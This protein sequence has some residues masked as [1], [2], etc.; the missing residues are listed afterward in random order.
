[1]K[2]SPVA[3]HPDSGHL[4]VAPCCSLLFSAGM[5]IA[6]LLCPDALRGSAPQEAP[7]QL[8]QVLTAR[9]AHL[10][11]EGHEATI[12]GDEL[13]GAGG[14]PLYEEVAA[15][16]PPINKLPTYGFVGTPDNRDKIG[17]EYGGRTANFDPAPYHPNIGSI[18]EQGKVLEGLVGGYLPVMRFVYPD[19]DRNW[20]ELLAFAPFRKVNS[21]GSIQP[22]WYRIARVEGGA[23]KWVKY[24]D[25]YH[26]FPPRIQ[27]EPALFWK[28]LIHLHA[29]WQ[30][31]F[32]GSMQVSLPD[33]RLANM[34]RMW[35]VREIMT[36][37]GDFP[38]YGVVD[39]N[40]AGSE[41]DGFPDTFTAG[42]EAMLL[43]G[44]VQRA[45]RYIDNY[46]RQFIDRKPLS[47]MTVTRFNES[48]RSY[49]EEGGAAERGLPT[50]NHIAGLLHLSP[51]YL[52][53]LLKQETG[54][55]ALELIHLYVISEAKNLLV[56]GDRTIAEIA[57]VLGFENPPYFSR[58]FK[59]EVGV[60]PKEFKGQIRN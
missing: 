30:K 43:W 60:S 39:R 57:Y 55:T 46:R 14:D 47:G 17:F 1:M 29:E 32:A 2:C 4:S 42:T 19:S 33:E 37:T 5:L 10:A 23:L 28:D 8:L 52:S 27:D 34:A 44:L 35:L 12:R 45:G 26:P 59:R 31:R 51:R 56:A 13:L 11:A 9:E 40:Y 20:C 6:L 24:I 49:F 18:R 16:L 25:S 41:H 22:V 3:C 48:L 53:D 54:K 7:P 21:S 38:H 15:A 50:V 58:L 36:R